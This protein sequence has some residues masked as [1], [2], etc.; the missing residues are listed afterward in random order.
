M[1]LS[2]FTRSNI[3]VTCCSLLGVAVNF[4]SQV[5]IAY[6]FGAQA[7]RDAYFTAITVPTY[8]VTLFVGSV[9]VVFLPFFVNFRKNHSEEDVQR[10]VSSISGILLLFLSLLTLAAYLFADQVVHASAPGFTEE[11][12]SLTVKLFRILIF[13]VTFQCLASIF[14]VFHHINGKF[15]LPAI[16]PIALPV[17]GLIFVALFHNY[18][19]VSL[20]A[21][22]LVG[23]AISA[24]LLL[25]PVWKQL[26]LRFLG[27]VS[28]SP[29]LHI[30]KI[31]APLFLTGILFRL[32]TIIE[33]IFAS[34]L[35][36]GSISYL[37]YANQLY[38]LMATI[39]TGSIATTY[40]PVL[41]AAWADNKKEEFEGHLQKGISL[42]LLIT[43][44]IAAV[45]LV[46]ANPII[47]ILF[48]RGAF[49]SNATAAVSFSLAILMGAFLFGSIGNLLMKVF[50]IAGK[51]TANSVISIAELVVY[52]LLAWWFAGKFSYPGLALALTLSKGFSI[53]VSAILLKRWNCISAGMFSSEL[54]KLLVAALACGAVS[55]LVYHQLEKQPAF[56]AASVS[57]LAGMLIY[58][59]MVFRVL[60]IKGLQL[61]FGSSKLISLSN[62]N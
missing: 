29:A 51:T 61:N 32:T 24:L 13:S 56:L 21:G 14:S 53:L 7:E 52:I 34:H 18:G 10:F 23:S 19:M 57:G 4:A 60:P 38:L 27:F 5:L 45:F 58:V 2:D 59:L 36:A 46:L 12:I 41:A 37:G 1:R 35:P 43:L 26:R 15:I 62:N 44:P 39:A 33:R 31:S 42:I 47:K 54:L 25:A 49:D 9:S 20:A 50:Y 11:Q 48:Q 28:N 22:T 40:Y 55:Y 6:Y 8:L 17:A 30:L 16:S 3:L